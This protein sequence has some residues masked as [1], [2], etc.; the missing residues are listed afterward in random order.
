MKILVTGGLGFIGHT[1][2]S[3]LEKQGHEIVIADSQT[4]Y[5]IIPPEQII[6]LMDQRRLHIKTD[7]IYPVDVTDR[8]DV[9]WLI[10]HHRPDR[11]LHLA[12]FPRQKV[13]N[14]NAP[15]GS[16]AMS[17]GLL[18][19]LEACVSNSVDRFVYISSSMVYGDFNN[20]VTED[21]V[22]CPQGQY[23][24]MKL[25]GEWLT[26][27][28]TRRTGMAHTI[29]R[30]T[31]VYGPRDVEDRVVSR[32]LIQAMRDQPI[33]VRGSTEQLDFSYVDDTAQGIVLSLLSDRSA[34]QTYN[35]SQ[36]QSRTLLEA[37]ELAVHI[38][39]R[40]RIEIQDRDLDF[41]SRGQLNITKAQQELG[42]DPQT[43]IQK[44]F[45]HYYDWLKHSIYWS[46]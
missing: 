2:V 10:S 7:R 19:L 31:A 22:C 36:G 15:A 29:V 6:W 8:A 3:L 13:V 18:N 41:P 23:G 46:T 4:T 16:R 40:G 25:A 30:P 20:D 21:A 24:I 35:I 28:Y 5:G 14:A 11:V 44:G 26:R 33:Q 43:N 38:A 1:V 39:G 27:D 32:F 12:S 17:E 42:F 45:Q 9:E 34:N 37:A